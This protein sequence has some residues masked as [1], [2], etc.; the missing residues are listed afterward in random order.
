MIIVV[1]VAGLLSMSGM[2]IRICILGCATIYGLFGP[3]TI[4]QVNEDKAL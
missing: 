1:R 4:R 3:R 2:L